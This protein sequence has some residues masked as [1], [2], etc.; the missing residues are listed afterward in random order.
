MKYIKNVA[1]IVLILST[2]LLTACGGEIKKLDVANDFA[3]VTVKI[4]YGEEDGLFNMKESS[5]L[6]FVKEVWDY[7]KTI[8]YNDDSINSDKEY[9]YIYLSFVDK[10]NQEIRFVVFDDGTCSFGEG[11]VDTY[12]LTNGVAVYKKLCE[13]Y[14]YA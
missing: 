5:S 1:I 8:E 7:Y 13:F 10:D 2:F 11:F 4:E 3:P 6:I 14:E 12:N 9:P